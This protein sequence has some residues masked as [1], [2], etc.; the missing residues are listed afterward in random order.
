M[1]QNKQ[2]TRILFVRKNLKDMLDKAVL[3]EGIRFNTAL[4]LMICSMGDVRSKASDWTPD[5][6]IFCYSITPSKIITFLSWLA[7]EPFSQNPYTISLYPVRKNLS[8]KTRREYFQYIRE[9]QTSLMY[10]DIT[11]FLQTQTN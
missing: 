6:I 2:K 3:P 10:L 7:E 9:F 4:E 5:A 11:K 8:R 1:K